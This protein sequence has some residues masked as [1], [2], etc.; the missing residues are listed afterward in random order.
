MSFL[1]LCAYTVARLC[2]HTC[3]KFAH[4]HT[5]PNTLQDLPV[6][7]AA[8]RNRQ[9]HAF[10]TT[11][12]PRRGAPTLLRAFVRC[13]VRQLGRPAMLAASAQG[14]VATGIAGL[15]EELGDALAAALEHLERSSL[16]LGGAGDCVSPAPGC[17]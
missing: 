17:L 5:S 7:Y 9:W 6:E 2:V 1:V 11:E 8:A 10:I 3:S 14:D 13:A 15:F 12:R 16:A 4:T